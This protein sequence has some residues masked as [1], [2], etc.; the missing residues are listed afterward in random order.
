MNSSNIMSQSLLTGVWSHVGRI[1]ERVATCLSYV[2]L[3]KYLMP[4]TKTSSVNF[5]EVWQLKTV[6]GESLP[7]DN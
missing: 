7:T 5:E 1:G 2:L 3:C 4:R 6:K